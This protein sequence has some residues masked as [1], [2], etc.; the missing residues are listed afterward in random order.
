MYMSLT[1]TYLEPYKGGQ[2][3][4]LSMD[5]EG[6]RFLLRGEVEEIEIHGNSMMVVRLLWLAKA[7]GSNLVPTGWVKDDGSKVYELDLKV[8]TAL[9]IGPVYSSMKE[10]RIELSS[11]H[12]VEKFIL[13]TRNGARI[14]PAAVEGLELATK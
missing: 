2:M 3:E 9:N 13:H 7:L 11:I 4:I 10:N 14:D 1:S 6:Q 8:Y 5:S 12:T